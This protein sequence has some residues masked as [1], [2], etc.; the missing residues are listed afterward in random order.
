MSGRRLLTV[1]DAETFLIDAVIPGY[2]PRQIRIYCSRGDHG[3]A[4]WMAR[5]KDYKHLT[6][7]I[8]LRDVLIGHEWT[9]TWVAE[10]P[11]FP[12]AQAA[13]DAAIE[14]GAVIA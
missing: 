7:D 6:G 10:Q 5:A 9:K 2:G 13:F 11:R 8:V 1:D 12:T 4:R 3:E 14:A